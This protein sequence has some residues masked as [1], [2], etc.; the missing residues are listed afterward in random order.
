MTQVRHLPAALLV[1][2]D[3]TLVDSEPI[4]DEVEYRITKE[5]GATLT[6]ELRA[7]FIGGPL[8]RTAQAILDLTGADISQD[9]LAMQILEEVARTIEHRGVQWLPGVAQFLNRMHNLHLPIA[10]VTASFHRIS[11]AIMDKAPVEGIQLLI[12]GDD[13]D[14][15]KPA[16]DGYLLAA[17]K[18]GVDPS[19]CIA[20]EDSYPGMC[21]AVAAGAR[22]IIVPGH[23]HVEL[24][25]GVCRVS[26]IDDITAEL[27]DRV[28]NGEVFDMLS[29]NTP[30]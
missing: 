2:Q 29:I 13:V 10:V 4:W 5:L 11:D 21:A 20:V 1:D 9:D 28:M 3:G 25:A 19:Q 26:S 12:A 14:A 15:P 16:P 23:S 18:L 6:P 7:T 27:L 17:H 8:D 30:S 22:T 24:L